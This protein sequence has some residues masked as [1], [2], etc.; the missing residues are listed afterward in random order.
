MDLAPFAF[1]GYINETYSSWGGR[2]LL[3]GQRFSCLAFVKAFGLFLKAL[4]LLSTGSPIPAE[5]RPALCYILTGRSGF[6][7][8]S[9]QI[10]DTYHLFATEIAK[11]CPLILFMN[12]SRVIH[13]TSKLPGGPY[14]KQSTVL[15]PF[16]HNPTAV[17][18]T[19]D[20]VYLLFFIGADELDP[21]ATTIDCTQ[22]VPSH[23]GKANNFCRG[24]IPLTNG[25]ISMAWA[26][27]VNGP[28]QT[29]VILPYNSTPSP[30]AWNCDNNNP[31]VAILPNGTVFMVYRANPCSGRGGEALGV[32]TAEHW[33]GEYVRRAGGP[34]VS[35]ASGSGNHE[36]PFVWVDKRGAFHIVS[37]DQSK[38]N[39]CGDNNNHGCGAH[40]YSQDSFTWQVGRF[41]LL[42][43]ANLT[44]SHHLSA[45]S[46][47][48]METDTP[49]PHTGWQ[50][51]CLQ[52][53]CRARKRQQGHSANTAATADPL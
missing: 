4:S 52:Q 18:P 45:H 37:H 35:P 26:K 8:F 39:V 34:I 1:E 3:V 14:V 7:F 21:A 38:G 33:S 23:C 5:V 46:G 49:D 16:H 41:K 12:N 44:L 9:L 22:G 6:V 48:R 47:S 32:A 17:G 24:T 28:W 31:A 19:P 36:D 2:P 42:T 40:L 50:S 11:E 20:G 51:T 13:A 29:R 53:R 27:D 15:P 25:Q 10:E 43:E 30:G